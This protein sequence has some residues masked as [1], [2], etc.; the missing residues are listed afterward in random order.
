VS[1]TSPELWRKTDEIILANRSYFHRKGEF[2]VK[3]I[4]VKVTGYELLGSL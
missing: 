2:V 3:C 1:K 4:R